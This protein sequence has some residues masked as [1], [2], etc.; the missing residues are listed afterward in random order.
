GPL[1]PLGGVGVALDALG[2][3]LAQG[4]AE[5]GHALGEAVARP[6]VEL[7]A[8]GAEVAQEGLT[9]AVARLGEVE[10]AGRR[11]AHPRELLPVA[12]LALKDLGAQPA[13]QYVV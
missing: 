1:E 8:L 11:R 13:Q 2:L 10:A 12:A 5:Q 4:Q 6:A 3:R 7:Q 9:Q